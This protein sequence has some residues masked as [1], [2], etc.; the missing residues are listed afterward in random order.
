MKA[1]TGA[2]RDSDANVD[3]D[4]DRMLTQRHIR[5]LTLMLTWIQIPFEGEET[6]TDDNMVTQKMH[7]TPTGVLTGEVTET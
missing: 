4:A 7:L 6:D 2:E 3:R 1:I 5:I